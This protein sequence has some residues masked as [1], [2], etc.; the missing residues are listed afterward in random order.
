MA[1][2]MMMMMMMMVVVVVM[3]MIRITMNSYDYLDDEHDPYELLMFLKMM[4][5]W[6]AVLLT[7]VLH[8]AMR[9]N[10]KIFLC[11]LLD[12]IGVPIWIPGRPSKT[13]ILVV[14]SLFAQFV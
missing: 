12:C 6:C 3:M 8:R 5:C 2:M 7:Q 9:I 4:V 14:L 1:M 11:R 13:E 10:G